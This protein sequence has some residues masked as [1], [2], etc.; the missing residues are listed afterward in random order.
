MTQKA[1]EFASHI[2]NPVTASTFAATLIAVALWMV[3]KSGKRPI[4]WLLAPLT[5]LL[6][7]APLGAHLFLAAEGVYRISIT[8]LGT[9]GQ[10]AKDAELKTLPATELHRTE[11]GFEVVL[12]PQLRPSDKVLALF[13]S[14]PSAYLAKS[15]TVALGSDY[16]PEATVQL[17]GLPSVTLHGEVLNEH[18]RGVEGAIVVLPECGDTVQSGKEGLFTV[19]SCKAKGQLLSIRASKDGLQD[20]QT[21]PADDGIQ[22]VLRRKKHP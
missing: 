2:T 20:S 13:A 18:Q 16:F 10:P 17:E 22:L 21:V 8:V 1:L 12:P 7:V 3:V 4:V 19:K 6:G 11:S 5:A 9:N 15:Q 14:I